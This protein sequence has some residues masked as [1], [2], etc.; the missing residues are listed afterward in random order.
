MTLAALFS[1]AVAREPEAVAIVDGE[2]RL[3]YGQ[4]PG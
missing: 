4:W 2:L 3:T 1:A